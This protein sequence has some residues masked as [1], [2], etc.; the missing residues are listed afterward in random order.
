LQVVE[1]G[2]KFLGAGEAFLGEE[3][4]ELRGVL[5]GITS[6][7]FDTY[8]WGNMDVS[9][10]GSPWGGTCRVLEYESSLGLTNSDLVSLKLRVG[11]SLSDFTIVFVSCSVNLQL[12]CLLCS[13]AVSLPDA[14]E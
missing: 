13:S 1:W 7:F 9:A 10:D 14:S 3:I 11:L 8:H 2:Q 4:V 6:K 12:Y 5:A